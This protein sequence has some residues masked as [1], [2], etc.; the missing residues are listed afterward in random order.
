MFGEWFYKEGKA[1]LAENLSGQSLK[2]LEK[3]HLSIHN[4]ARKIIESLEQQ[5]EGTEDYHGVLNGLNG[6]HQDLIKTLQECENS[7]VYN[8]LVALD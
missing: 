8:Y 1:I 6:L 4:E 7:L 3:V 5:P 2:E